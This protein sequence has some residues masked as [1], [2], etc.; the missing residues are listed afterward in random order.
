IASIPFFWTI[1]LAIYL[2][3]FI[4]AFGRPLYPLPNL[5]ARLSALALLAVVVT[6]CVEANTPAAFLIPLHLV[7]FFLCCLFCHVRVTAL[8]PPP[9]LLPQY[10]LAISLGGA[11]G[12]LVTLLVPPLLTDGLVEYPIALVLAS[13]AMVPGVAGSRSAFRH[14]L[15]VA[16][17]AALVLV[18][19]PLA[20][21]FFP[22]SIFGPALPYFP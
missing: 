15:D 17:P 7:V 19:T 22:D 20:T 18:G 14:A 9:S 6:L 1:P 2:A 13:I 21:R 3:T 16:I 12:G 5:L 10:Y 8:Q 11:V 4:L